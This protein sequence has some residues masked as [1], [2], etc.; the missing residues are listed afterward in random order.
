MSQQAV[1]FCTKLLAKKP[2]ERLRASEALQHPWIVSQR[3][4]R[5]REA[6]VEGKGDGWGRHA[7]LVTALE[8]FG[9]GGPLK[10]LALEV[11]SLLISLE[12]P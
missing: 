4:R 5:Q 7:A 6:A 1:D 10:Q 2:S 8:R 11:I 3:E 9:G 12:L